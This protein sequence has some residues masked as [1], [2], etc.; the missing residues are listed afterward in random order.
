[1]QKVSTTQPVKKKKQERDNKD[2]T[3]GMPPKKGKT[4]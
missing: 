1:M 2:G 4:K 3:K